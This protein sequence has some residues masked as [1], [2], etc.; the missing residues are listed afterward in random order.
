A[1]DLGSGAARCES[2]SLSDRTIIIKPS[3]CWV[4]CF[5]LLAICL[6]SINSPT[7]HHHYHIDLP[8]IKKTSPKAL[9]L[10]LKTK[11]NQPEGWLYSFAKS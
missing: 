4:L 1:P 8:F 3:F 6:S 7:L 11:K 10:S 9:Q 5:L 2:S